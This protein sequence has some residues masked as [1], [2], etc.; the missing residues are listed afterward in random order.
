M[1]V[2]VEALRSRSHYGMAT[3]QRKWRPSALTWL[4]Y[5]IGSAGLIVGLY[6]QVSAWLSSYNQS[7]IV[8]NYDAELAHA[9][10]SVEEQIRQAREY[11]DA[12]SAGVVLES[13]ANVASGVGT[14]SNADLNY[15][16]ILKANS[17]G[18]MARLKVPV[19][20]IDI[21]VYHGTSDEVLL[22][23]S[24]HLE[25]SHLP[26]GGSS[27]RSVLTAHRGLASSTMF[28]NLDKVDV[29]DTF[30]IEVFGEILVYQVFDVKVIAPEEKDTLR[31]E[32]GKDLVTLITCTPLGI[33]SHRI[34]VTGERVSN[35][36]EEVLQE[37]ATAPT[38]PGFPWWAIWIFAGF[39]VLT[40]YL[41]WQGKVDAKRTATISVDKIKAN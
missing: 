35:V 15:N 23:G 8:E 25:G 1:S 38:I 9:R 2:Q 12:L 27:T 20:D 26:V 16:D 11:N 21:P 30:S 29:G 31:V 13:N 6:P 41:L 22:K 14:L 36:P 3:Q 39:T 37:A 7:Q 18:L 19:V 24:G 34:L 4:I 10:P 40:C 17:Q 32:P 5:C 28:T 33:N